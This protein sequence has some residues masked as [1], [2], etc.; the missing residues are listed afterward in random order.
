M[1]LD[2]FIATLM[3]YGPERKLKIVVGDSLPI[4]DFE[5]KLNPYFDMKTGEHLE[6]EII[7]K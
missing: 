3:Q 7:P 2:E 5:I 6:I 4:N 1:K